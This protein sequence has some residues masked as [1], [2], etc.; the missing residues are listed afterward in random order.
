MRLKFHSTIPSSLFY[1][2][3]S[4]MM[5]SLPPFSWRRSSEIPKICPHRIFLL[6]HHSWKKNFINNLLWCLPV[7][8]LATTPAPFILKRLKWGEIDTAVSSSFAWSYHNPS[9]QILPLLDL[10]KPKISIRNNGKNLQHYFWYF[11]KLWGRGE[12]EWSPNIFN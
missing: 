10:T 9:G 11:L 4:L 3:F 5:T 1:S 2:L 12:L 7:I 6:V 8:Y